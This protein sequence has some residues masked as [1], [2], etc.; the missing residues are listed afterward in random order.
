MSESTSF[1]VLVDDYISQFPS[2]VQIKLQALRQMIRDSAPNAVE[3]ISYKMPTYAEHGNLVHFAAYSK[4][5]GFYPGASGIEAFKEELSRYKGAKGSVQ[6]PLDQPLPEELIRRIV[7]FRVQ[8]NVEKAREK[9][10]KK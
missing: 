3:K 10:R 6:F 5:I 1:D 2:D 8:A 7:E 9:K 4:H